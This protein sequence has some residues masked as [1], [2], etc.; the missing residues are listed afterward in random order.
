MHLDL[1]QYIGKYMPLPNGRMALDELVE[2]LKSAGYEVT[3][4]VDRPNIKIVTVNNEYHVTLNGYVRRAGRSKERF[5]EWEAERSQRQKRKV[6]NI[7]NELLW[8]FEN[9]TNHVPFATWVKRKMHEEIYGIWQP[10]QIRPKQ[11]ELV[12][13]M[14]LIYDGENISLCHISEFHSKDFM[15]WARIPSHSFDEKKQKK[16]GKGG[17]RNG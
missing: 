17:K 9:T 3:K 10:K 14:V 15:L 12:K 6:V 16:K 8:Q 2:Y 5:N 11:S 7:D 1:S 13:E 4:I